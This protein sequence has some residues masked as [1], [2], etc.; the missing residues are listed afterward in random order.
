MTRLKNFFKFHIYSL[1]IFAFLIIYNLIFVGFHPFESHNIVYQSYLI[2]F[3]VG[4]CTKI[5]PGAFYNLLFNDLSTKAVYTYCFVLLIVFFALAS[6]V[7][8]KL[9]K[10]ID[11]GNRKILLLIL[12]FFISGTTAFSMH[13]HIPGAHDF[14]WMVAFFL[15]LLC[16]SSKHL[17]ILIIP[18]SLISVIIN[19]G[20]LVSAFPFL[21]LLMIYKAS[22]LSEKKNK[23][24]LLI[25][26]IL[27]TVFSFL[28][29]L[30]FLFFEFENLKYTA[31]EF[32]EM[33]ESKGNL[34]QAALYYLA[35]LYNQ[36]TY[37]VLNSS[38]NESVVQSVET[39]FQQ[40]LAT[41]YHRI[42]IAFDGI[43]WEAGALAFLLYI[44]WLILIYRYIQ[45]RTKTETNKLK[46][47]SLNLIVPF[48][49]FTV[50]ICL[51]L[52]RDII[53]FMGAIYSYMFTCFLYVIYSQKGKGLDYLEA[54][55]NKHSVFLT[56]FFIIYFSINMSPIT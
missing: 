15:S 2:D 40:A 50:L 35:T 42:L 53:R 56:A 17:Y 14:Y 1:S 7:L 24:Y 12:L 13:V 36:D 9:I 45:N 11:Y 46:S 33:L 6:V 48:F 4:F 29:G 16:L 25:I 30:Y 8:E 54:L 32:S 26:T 27:T 20:F 21:I 23:T 52:S 31:E 22:T 44:P 49:F 41:V 3:S 10:A 51:F 43:N 5:L 19:Y 37:G 34:K 39:P 38:F 28:L 18:L 47:F 55:I